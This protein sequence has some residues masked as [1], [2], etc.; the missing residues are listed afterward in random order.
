[1]QERV[2]MVVVGGEGWVCVCG[3]GCFYWAFHWAMWASHWASS[4]LKAYSAFLAVR[5]TRSASLSDKV[6]S[7]AGSARP[8]ALTPDDPLRRVAA[9]RQSCLFIIS[10]IYNYRSTLGRRRASL[11]ND[12][13]PFNLRSCQRQM[14]Y[15]II[16][17]LII[18]KSIKFESSAGMR[19]FLGET[20]WRRTYQCDWLPGTEKLFMERSTSNFDKDIREKKS[21]LYANESSSVV[22]KQT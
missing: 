20:K 19:A 13:A 6:Q 18:Y 2:L 8:S 12:C 15:P 7:S 11:R 3:E 5:L 16:D 21:L 4:G 14:L 1:M 17:S 9:P 10:C 22:W